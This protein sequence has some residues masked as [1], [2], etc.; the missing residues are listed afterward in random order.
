MNEFDKWNELKK[1]IDERKKILKFRQRDIWFLNI[2]KNI[3]YEQNGKGDEFLRPVVV[4]RKFSNRY[5][6]GV[7]LSSKEK[8]G[9]YFFTFY[10]KGKLQTA[11]LNQTRVFDI[12]R[13]KF[14][15]GRLG[16][17]TFDKLVKNYIKLLTPQEREVGPLGQ[18]TEYIISQNSQKSNGFDKWNELK[19]EIDI[20]EKI[21]KF[22]EREIF[23]ISVGKNIGYEQNGKGDEFLRPVLIIKKF[24]KRFFLGILLTKQ[25]K[26][27]DYYF[28][29]NE[30]SFAILS[31][32]RVF[33]AK[34]MK[35]FYKRLNENKFYELIERIENLLP[36]R[37]SGLTSDLSRN[38]I[39]QK[40]KKNKFIWFDLVT[41]KSVLF[42][43]P[44]IE[45]LKNKGKKV[46]ITARESE[47]YKEVVDLLKLYNLEFVNRGEFGGGDLKDKLKASINRQKELM[48]FVSEFN[49]KKLVCLS[50][51]D[52]VRVAFG[53]GI[54][55][56]NFY[57]IPL[58]D[59]KT[60]FKKALPQAR[61]TIPLA[62]KMFKPF[63][64]PDEVILRFGLEKEQIIEYNFID[65][66]IWL[67]NFKFNK[68]YVEKIYKRYNIDRNKFTILVREEEYKASYVN[69]KYPFL[70]EAL[71]LIYKKFN[72]NIII[73]PRY[74]SE[75]L[76]KE[77]PFAYVIEEKIILQHLLED[78]DLFLGGGGT[79]NTEACFLG[80]PT[81]STRSFIS[82]YDKWQIDNNLMVWT[83]NL[84]ELINY[85]KLAKEKKLKPDISKLNKMKVNIDMFIEEITKKANQ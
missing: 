40:N 83:N 75:Y 39:S 61:L 70:Y 67:K 60:N 19:K 73:I 64:V 44:I 68:T 35:Y 77:F 57:D 6:L 37:E 12:K 56:Y 66:L 47:D 3:G 52:A 43:R 23:F 51:V 28:K 38:I 85:V 18:K 79:I 49:I 11:L 41:P 10:H 72:A 55:V 8:I 20:R 65:P 13:K 69:K 29:L 45:E 34:R 25:G 33:D 62:T 50:S 58:S 24:N 81:I 42:F 9:S 53:L 59:Y 80:T 16:K 46:L 22:K 1:E 17:N 15:Y 4:L 30:N 48:E 54:P 78:V 82:H 76:K 74:E 71:P 31:Q 26:N 21:L 14:F 7:P 2:G 84:N 32:I 27:S 5:F 36:K 63:V